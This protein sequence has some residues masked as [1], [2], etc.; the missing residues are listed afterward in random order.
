MQCI[1]LIQATC[2]PCHPGQQSSIQRSRST[3][4]ACGACSLLNGYEEHVLANVAVQPPPLFISAAWLQATLASHSNQLVWRSC[5][6]PARHVAVCTA[7]CTA[8]IARRSTTATIIIAC[9]T[10]CAC[11]PATAMLVLLHCP[12]QAGALHTHVQP[13]KPAHQCTTS[14]RTGWSRAS[15]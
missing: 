13:S 9:Y 4:T 10:A 8:D 15:G 3:P 7:G 2:Y 11:I 12:V 14:L 1:S 5:N 6:W